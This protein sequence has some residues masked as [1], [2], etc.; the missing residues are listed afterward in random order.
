MR[1]RNLVFLFL[2][3]LSPIFALAQNSP[4]NENPDPKKEILTNP[5]PLIL[6]PNTP[7]SWAINLNKQGGI[8]GTYNF[9]VAINSNGQFLCGDDDKMRSVSVTTTSFLELSEM[10]DKFTEN[11][12]SK[13]INEALTYC[14]DCIYNS[15]SFYRN[16][17]EEKTIAANYHSQPTSD[18][19]TVKEV[20]A[21]VWQVTKCDEN[22]KPKN[23]KVN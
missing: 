17:P 16:K 12:Y 15:L 19:P 7:D 1:F 5:A 10:V 8:L 13:P 9:L 21:K 2:L 23:K 20:F 22:P 3:L 14:N 11:I 6:L 18:A 4:N